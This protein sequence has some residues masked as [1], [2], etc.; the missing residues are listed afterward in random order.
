VLRTLIP[1]EREVELAEGRMIYLMQVRP[2]RD[3]NNVI[4]GAVITFVDIS[5]RK[6]HQQAQAQLAAIVQSSQDAIISHDLK[7]V[8]T[9][10]NAGAEALLGYPASQAIGQPIPSLLLSVPR[11]EMP[12]LK[13]Q[14]VE[15]EQIQHFESAR[16]TADGHVIEFSVTTSPVRQPDGQVVGASVIARDISE[17]KRADRKAALLLSELDHRVKNILAI[18]SS[19]VA[20]TVSGSTSLAACGEELEGRITA[21]A[22][23]HSLLTQTGEGEVSLQKIIQTELAP[24]DRGVCSVTVTG[25]DV[26]LTPKA[27]LSMAM[28][29]HELAS[30]AA[31]YGALSAAGG[32]VQVETRQREG[33]AGPLFC[34]SWT[35]SGG[36]PVTVPTRRGFGTMLIERTLALD[37]DAEVKRDFL[38]DGLRCIFVF[39]LSEEFGRVRPAPPMRERPGS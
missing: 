12:R 22:K 10:W 19:V 7:G 3:L 30:N 11:N 33:E 31:K 9:S 37:L 24:F 18:V 26:A 36:P 34:L 5:D 29:I 6:K 32:R 28:A 39:P 2:Y 25:C 21:I 35:E 20:Q 27:G 15:G 13:A 16:T 14:L 1:I 8:V 4:N 38:P 17:S 23:A